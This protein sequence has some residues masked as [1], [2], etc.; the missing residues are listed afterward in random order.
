[1]QK[2]YWRKRIEGLI[3][4]DDIES[5]YEREIDPGDINFTEEKYL[6]TL[7]A[8]ITIFI[9]MDSELKDIKITKENMPSH[10]F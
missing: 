5:D 1:M 6:R 9:R 7:L 3:N 2:Q 4:V 8:I 10:A